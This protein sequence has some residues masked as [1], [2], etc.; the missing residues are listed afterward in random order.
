LLGKHKVG[1]VA[2][3]SSGPRGPETPYGKLL[4]PKRYTNPESSGFEIDV[5]PS[6]NDDVVFEMTTKEQPNK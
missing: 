6:G 2:Y 4:V 1:I 5:Q 3:D